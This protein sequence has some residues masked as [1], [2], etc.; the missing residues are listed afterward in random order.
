MGL[1]RGKPDDE[2]HRAIADIRRRL[3]AIERAA[4]GGG[5]GP[6]FI[7]FAPTGQI[8]SHG[9]FTK[10]DLDPPE[11]DRGGYFDA[12]NNL[13]QPLVAGVYQVGVYIKFLSHVDAKRYDPALYKN[14]TRIRL[15]TTSSSGAFDQGFGMSTLVE[16]NGTSDFLELFGRQN[17]GGDL[18]IS[19]AEFSAA[20]H[21]PP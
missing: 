13:Y 19:T 6:A 9:A 14:G 7:A 1:V 10:I 12:A 5:S 16:M 20:W 21:G 18:T 17:T 11:F 2:L 3:R 8:L 15:Y 4:T